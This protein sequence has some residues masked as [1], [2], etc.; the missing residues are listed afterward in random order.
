M[1]NKVFYDSVGLLNEAKR[2]HT[3]K[4]FL[5][6]FYDCFKNSNKLF[7]IGAGA[8]LLT[9]ASAVSK[10]FYCL[11]TNKGSIDRAKKFIDSWRNFLNE[12]PFCEEFKLLNLKEIEPRFNNC[13]FYE[14]N[15]PEKIPSELKQCMDGA[16]AS[17]LFL[18]LRD[19]EAKAILA[20]IK[21]NLKSNSNFL[22]S[23]Y[24]TGNNDSLDFCFIDLGKK[25]G[26]DP[27][28]FIDGKIIQI[29]KLFDSI[30]MLEID[31]KTINNFW[32]DLET[33]RVYDRQILETWIKEA[34]FNIELIENV[35]GGMFSFADRT[36]Y[37]LK[38]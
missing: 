31:S 18:H 9:I 17:E 4:R 24:L 19:F 3:S 29:K 21:A 26:V 20:G 14:G 2:Y 25:Y 37:C 15:F 35:K 11:D 13:F 30:K 12:D 16:F 34:G 7:S 32:L 23:V 28:V 5:E 27:A 1:N 33:V 38:S 6:L 22:F 10:N 8:R 36:I